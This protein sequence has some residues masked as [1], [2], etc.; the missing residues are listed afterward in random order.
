M[1][2]VRAN[3]HNWGTMGNESVVTDI[4]NNHEFQ[5]LSPMVTAWSLLICFK[6]RHFYTPMHGRQCFPQRV[7]RFPLA[8]DTEKK[9]EPQ[10]QK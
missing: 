6:T 10:R 2:H 5:T 8:V 4:H 7:E 9:T 3:N 1:S